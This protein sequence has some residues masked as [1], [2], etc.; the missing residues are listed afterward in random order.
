MGA[1]NQVQDTNIGLYL[2]KIKCSQ[3]QQV[4]STQDL[5]ENNFDLWWDNSNDIEFKES[6]SW[7]WFGCLV[8]D[9]TH[10]QKSYTNYQLEDKYYF[11]CPDTERCQGCYNKFLA[12][13]VKEF[14]DYYYC[15]PC[16]Q[17]ITNHHE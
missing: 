13:Q 17:Q 11:A 10:K 16:Y 2:A 15:Q 8:R 9:F 12:E 4:F 5:K 6:G 3:C 1:T 14:D 7:Y